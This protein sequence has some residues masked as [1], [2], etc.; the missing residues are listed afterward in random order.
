VWGQPVKREPGYYW[1]QTGESVHPEIAQLDH[2]GLWWLISCEY[3]YNDS[4]FKWIDKPENRLTPP[5]DGKE[6]S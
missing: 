6:N 3:T 1:V 2:F 5:E 4:H